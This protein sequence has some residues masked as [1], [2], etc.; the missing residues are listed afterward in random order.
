[1]LWLLKGKLQRSIHQVFGCYCYAVIQFKTRIIAFC[2]KAEYL[3][4]EFHLT[5][6]TSSLAKYIVNILYNHS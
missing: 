6:L 4:A 5:F 2:I 1:M 3:F